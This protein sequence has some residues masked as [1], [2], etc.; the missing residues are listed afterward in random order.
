MDDFTDWS[1]WQEEQPPLEVPL[2]FGVFKNAA[3]PAPM[4]SQLYMKEWQL[5]L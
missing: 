2:G 5:H 4:T 3:S 1:L